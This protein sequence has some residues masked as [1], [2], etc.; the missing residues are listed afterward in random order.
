MGK[1]C[2]LEIKTSTYD[3]EFQYYLDIP[4]E[5]DWNMLMS[6]PAKQTFRPG[7]WAAWKYTKQT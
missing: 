4:I 5:E 6:V 7:L 2:T 3:E 1:K